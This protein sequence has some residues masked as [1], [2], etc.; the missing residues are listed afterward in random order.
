VFLL[1]LGGCGPALQFARPFAGQPRT[2][3]FFDHDVPREFID[4]NGRMLT[5]WGEETEF[6]D[7]HEGYD[8]DLPVGTPLLAVEDAFV[9]F[10]G[11]GDPFFCPRL[12]KTTQDYFVRLEMRHR[13]DLVRVNYQH[14]SRL[15]VAKGDWVKKGQVLGLSGNAGCSTGPH[16]HL[17][18]YRQNSQGRLVAIDPFGFRAGSDPWEGKGGA[19][20]EWLWAPG[21]APELFRE[22]VDPPNPNGSSSW[23][24]ITRVRWQGVDDAHH[25]NNE[26]VDLTLDTR[27]APER[28]PMDRYVL[29]NVAGDVFNFPAGFAL[30]RESPTVRIYSGQGTDSP[31]TLHWGQ[32]EG[33][34]RNLPAT[35][36]AVLTFPNGNRYT[37]FYG[38]E[39][40]C[41][42]AAPVAARHERGAEG[43]GGGG[44][45]HP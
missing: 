44:A 9:H 38:E 35:D 7:G 4:E 29:T 11:V 45:G 14:M 41:P 20:S 31:T 2:T 32:A 39:N 18:V 19:R 13:G 25:P 33:I 27:Y 36:C 3:N 6:L 22:N 42:R 15:D 30:T 5:Y 17:V 40:I 43:G 1:G 26:F 12:K 37:F 8:F 34:W 21:Q 28:V 23:V 10:A 24:T 16:L